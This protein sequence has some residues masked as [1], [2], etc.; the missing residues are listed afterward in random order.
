MNKN[1]I[2]DFHGNLGKIFVGSMHRVSGLE[3]SN[4]FPLVVSKDLLSFFRPGKF[5]KSLRIISFTQGSYR[6]PPQIDLSLVINLLYSRMVLVICSKNIFCFI[7]Y[8]T[9]I[10][11]R[12]SLLPKYRWFYLQP[13]LFLVPLLKFSLVPSIPKG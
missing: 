1:T 11:P 7:F 4:S 2:T 9:Y 3:S 8:R 13:K 12:W 10:F 6:S 5:R